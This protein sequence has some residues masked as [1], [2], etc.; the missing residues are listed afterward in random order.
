MGKYTV[1]GFWKTTGMA[2]TQRVWGN[3]EAQARQHAMEIEAGLHT[4][5][6]AEMYLKDL[7]VVEVFN[8]HLVGLREGYCISGWEDLMAR[9]W[10]K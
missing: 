8:D 6:L 1:V 3:T 9:E 5:Q 10:P 7:C 4:D 2:F